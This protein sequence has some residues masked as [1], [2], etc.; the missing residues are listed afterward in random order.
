MSFPV[1]TEDGPMFFDNV[2]A[3]HARAAVTTTPNTLNAFCTP[4]PPS[5]APSSSVNPTRYPKAVILSAE[6]GSTPCYITTDGV[7]TPSAT[8][9]LLVPT[10]PAIMRLSLPGGFGPRFA[11]KAVAGS[12]TATVQVYW[13]F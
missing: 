8:L 10:A 9:G 1:S 11:V 13:E 4:P 12:G 3:L 6:V 7:T 2:T 5:I